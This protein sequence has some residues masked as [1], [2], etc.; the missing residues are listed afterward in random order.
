[1]YV[2]QMKKERAGKTSLSLGTGRDAYN[3]ERKDAGGS[4]RDQW[5]GKGRKFRLFGVDISV[6]CTH[7]GLS[8]IK[9]AQKGNSCRIEGGEIAGNHAN[10]N[11]S[12]PKF[13][14]APNARKKGIGTEKQT[15]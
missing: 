15:G 6:T 11:V 4:E 2:I 1:M 9:H 8:S 13:L 14:R 10:L 12:L 7:K 5:S 3:K